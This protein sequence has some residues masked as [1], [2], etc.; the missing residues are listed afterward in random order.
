MP[1]ARPVGPASSGKHSSWQF[2]PP[3]AGDSLAWEVVEGDRPTVARS[4]LETAIY[5][6]TA[7]QFKDVH[8]KAGA[9]H[10]QGVGD[11]ASCADE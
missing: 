7:C 1:S 3:C 4:R 10:S 5:I 6:H 8:V 2:Y 9:S 11:M